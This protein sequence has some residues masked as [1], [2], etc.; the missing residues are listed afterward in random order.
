[1]PN[2]LASCAMSRY[3]VSAILL[4]LQLRY[5]TLRFMLFCFATS[6]S[7]FAVCLTQTV[8][9]VPV[10]PYM[11]MFDGLSFLSAGASMFAMCLMCS[12]LCGICSGV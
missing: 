5:T 7:F 12:S 11:N 1:M 9:P 8:L 10:L 3:S 6:C 2:S 4:S